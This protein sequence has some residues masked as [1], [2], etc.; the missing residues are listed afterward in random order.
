MQ[1]EQLQKILSGQ[2]ALDILIVEGAVLLGP[3]G[4][5]MYDAREGVPNKNLIHDLAHQAQFVIALGTC[6]CY[7]G[8]NAK[9]RVESVGLQ[10]DG[11][12]C[13]GFLGKEFRTKSGYPVVNL[14]GCPC[15][16]DVVTGALIALSHGHTCQLDEF[17]RPKEWFNTSIH[18]GCTRNEYHEYRVE[19]SSFGESGCL[20]FHLG[21][22]G[23]LVLGPCNKL[24]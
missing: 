5:G 24:L 11:Y 21:C 12:T 13:G 6:A 14:A 7:G 18:Q 8:V 20:F 2:Q 15:H 10:F 19:E 3:N 9:E 22:H 17:H 1:K 16:H 4:T 23:P